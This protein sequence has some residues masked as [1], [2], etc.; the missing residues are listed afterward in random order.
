MKK[1]LIL[2]LF[3]LPRYNI[4]HWKRKEINYI[5]QFVSFPQCFSFLYLSVP[6]LKN[7]PYCML[8]SLQWKPRLKCVFVYMVLKHYL[9][10]ADAVQYI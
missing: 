8:F 10:E 9:K 1:Y 2:L 5:L 6:K 3:F 7:D 4:R